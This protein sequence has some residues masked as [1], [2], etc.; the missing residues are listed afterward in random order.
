[1]SPERSKATAS[2]QY[3]IPKKLVGVPPLVPTRG[4]RR[5]VAW[6]RPGGG[7]GG[8]RGWGRWGRRGGAGAARAGA[9]GGERAADRVAEERAGLRSNDRWPRYIMT[10]LYKSQVE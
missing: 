2:I 9:E 4:R 6:E 1:M 7:G 8:G 3:R 5:K 10:H